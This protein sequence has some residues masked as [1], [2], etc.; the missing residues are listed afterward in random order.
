MTKK[1]AGSA[2]QDGDDEDDDVFGA[3]DAPEGDREPAGQSP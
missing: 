1:A 3:G 2:P